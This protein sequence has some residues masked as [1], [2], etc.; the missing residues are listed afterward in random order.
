MGRNIEYTPD[1]MSA[2]YGHGPK[3]RGGCLHGEDDEENEVGDYTNVGA[4]SS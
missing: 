4:Y 3:I 1:I 2:Q